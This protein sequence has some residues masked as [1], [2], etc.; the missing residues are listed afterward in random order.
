MA[1]LPRVVIPDAAH[2]VT[3]LGDARQGILAEE[4]A[5]RFSAA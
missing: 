4:I 1:R 5:A 2:H 3:Q